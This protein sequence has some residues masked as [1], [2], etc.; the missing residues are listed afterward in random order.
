[1]EFVQ[2]INVNDNTAPVVTCTDTIQLDTDPRLCTSTFSVP[3]PTVVDACSDFSDLMITIEVPGVGTGLGPHTA[4]PGNYLVNYS[5][6]DCSGSVET[7]STV[8][9]IE[10]N[11]E[12]NTICREF[13]V[14]SLNSSGSV[15]A[16]AV[17]FD[18]GSYDNCDNIGF[19]VSR[20]MVNFENSVTFTCDDAG[21][22]SIMVVLRVFELLNPDQYSDCMMFVEV[23]DKL[24]PMVT[25]PSDVTIDC[26]EDHSDLSIYG[27]A[28]AFDPCG[29]QIVE[30]VNDSTN[31]CGTGFIERIFIAT[32]SSGNVGTCKQIITIENQAPFQGS[33]I[34]WPLDTT[35]VVCDPSVAPDDLLPGYD[36]PSY[37]NDDCARI[38]RNFSD[39]EYIVSYPA[40]YKIFRKWKVLDWCT[41]NIWEHRQKI[42]IMDT[43]A[44]AVN[45]P[46]DYVIS[47][48]ANCTST[49]VNMGDLTAN[50]C[51]PSA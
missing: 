38:L 12:P 40:C 9:I 22:D 21:T 49:R 32:D 7:C 23:Q 8:L 25:C 46:G 5:V 41:G 26:D 14:V 37:A 48:S 43:E 47:A 30:Q 45:C 16:Y 28:T 44:P 13:T 29:F 17:S 6:S 24:T 4:P 39:E 50:D 34:T 10:D 2:F 15:E 11:E 19:L 51:D 18:E 1:M 35:F 42:I 33:Q 27:Q 3:N 20:D 31:Q 36:Y